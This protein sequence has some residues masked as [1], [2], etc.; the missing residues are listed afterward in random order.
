MKAEGTELDTKPIQL[1]EFQ[2]L[3][4]KLQK[5]GKILFKGKHHLVAFV[6]EKPLSVTAV[7]IDGPS[8]IK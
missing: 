7:G 8:K 6:N 3:D 4:L 2:K 5:D 1:K